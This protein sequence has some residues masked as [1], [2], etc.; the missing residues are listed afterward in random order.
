[1]KKVQ[2]YHDASDTMIPVIPLYKGCHDTSDM[3][4]LD[5]NDT[6]HIMILVIPLYTSHKVMPLYQWYNDTSDI[7]IPYNDT[8]MPVLLRY[9]WNHDTTL[10]VIPLQ[11]SFYYTSDTMIQVISWCLWYHETSGTLL[12]F[13]FHVTNNIQIPL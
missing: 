4:Y 10:P 8:I 7:L 6:T 5:T 3:R 12:Y 1:M 2:W 13:S 11:Q 9:Q